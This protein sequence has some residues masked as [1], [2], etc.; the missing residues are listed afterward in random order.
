MAI[1][2]ADDD[3]PRRQGDGFPEIV[4]LAASD[5]G[6]ANLVELVSRSFLDTETGIRPHVSLV[7]L[8]KKADGLIALTGGALGLLGQPLL[9][10]R[11][12]LATRRFERLREIFGDRLYVEL[13]RHGNR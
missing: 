4:L 7:A 2:C 9:D 1:D 11:E 6:Y 10:G 5:A 3:A 13:Q 12:D 8:A